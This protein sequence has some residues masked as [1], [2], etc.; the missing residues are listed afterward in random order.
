MDEK[1]I[2]KEIAQTAKA[3]SNPIDFEK[4]IQNGIL[5][6][7]GRSY[8]VTNIEALPENVSKRIKTATTTKEGLRVTFHNKSKSLKKIADQLNGYLE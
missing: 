7:K 6:K 5:T 2:I 8:F 3:F 1:R 4:L